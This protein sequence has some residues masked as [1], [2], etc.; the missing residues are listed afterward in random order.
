MESIAAML[1]LV[2]M[3]A[4]IALSFGIHPIHFGLVVVFNFS[5][6]MITPPYGITLF[7]ASSVAGR[8]ILQVSKRIVWPLLA[9]M[10]TLAF[11]TYVPGVSLFLP[12]LVGLIE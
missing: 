5:I 12:R 6:G 4:P 10:G 3:L 9:M 1:V 8:S 2:P 11:V 7:V